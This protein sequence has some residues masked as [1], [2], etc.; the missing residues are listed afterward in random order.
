MMEV[1]IPERLQ[2][3]VG[4]IIQPEQGDSFAG[5]TNLQTCFIT[6]REPASQGASVHNHHPVQRG[7]A[8][9]LASD[10]GTFTTHHTLVKT[11]INYQTDLD[12]RLTRDGVGKYF[13][14]KLAGRLCGAQPMA[15]E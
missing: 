15:R 10:N 9:G 11:I 14:A 5:V 1:R 3:R 8:A 6:A 13:I 4:V 7:E 2:G 12:S